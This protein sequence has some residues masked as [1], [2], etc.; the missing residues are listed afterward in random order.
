MAVL[1]PTMTESA[2]TALWN[3]VDSLPLVF[4]VD[5]IH[6]EQLENAALKQKILDSGVKFYPA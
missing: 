4:K 3:E 2:F 6:F 1:A 5:C